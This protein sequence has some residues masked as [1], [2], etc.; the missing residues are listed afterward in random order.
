MGN[1]GELRLVAKVAGAFPGEDWA[2]GMSLGIQRR[3]KLLRVQRIDVEPDLRRCGVGTML[4]ERAAA[5]AC[6][7]GLRLASDRERSKGA[8]TFWRKQVRKGRARCIDRKRRGDR[9]EPGRGTQERHWK[10]GQYALKRAACPRP[11]L[12]GRRR[13]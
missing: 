7:R 10:C 5:E 4:Y 1:D 11:M 6:E 9:Y 3:R 8:E 13:R 12:S 2:G